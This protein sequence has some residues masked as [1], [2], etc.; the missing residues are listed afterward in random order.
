MSSSSSSS[1]TAALAGVWQRVWEEDP[2]GDC[3]GADRDTLVLWTQ[4][5]QSGFYVDV[6]LPRGSPARQ[7]TPII[8]PRP[9]A[10]AAN[11]M[12]DACKQILQANDQLF[13]SLLRQKSFAGVLDCRLGDT[14]ESG[15]ALQQDAFLKD[16]ADKASADHQDS[17]AGG[18]QPLALCTCF[19]RRDLDYQPTPSG[20]DIG[21]CASQIPFSDG[22]VLL[23]ETGAD[24][25]YAE[26]W[27]RLAG[28][29][30]IGGPFLAL[31]LL[32]ETTNGKSDSDDNKIN[33]NKEDMRRRAGVWVRT[34]NR[35]AY[36]V[37]YPLTALD[38]QALHAP[39][40]SAKIKDCQSQSLQDVFKTLGIGGG[41]GSDDK[42]AM[43]DVLGCY[44]AATGEI[45]AD[46]NRWSIQYSTHPELVGCELVGN[47]AISSSGWCSTLSDC[48]SN[49]VEQTIPTED[50]GT[51]KRKWK[52]VEQTGCT[53][54]F[55]G[56]T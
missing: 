24:A 20:L 38:A 52:V 46:D 21:V 13:Q 55:L 40:L 50:G 44:V 34:N 28:T 56:N 18:A 9:S 35:F 3:A 2:I 49:V 11:G 15:A 12:S 31:E 5:P 43:L 14:T 39:Q 26:E 27:L 19:W 36:A 37:G 42:D 6:R 45:M 16:L 10:L 7:K 51:A 17:F 48:G 32:S 22:S 47:K 33:N 25:S 53:L 54:P 8:Q 30:K 4:T 1:N 41:G 29:D 23:R